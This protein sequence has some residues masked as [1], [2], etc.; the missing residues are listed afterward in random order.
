MSLYDLRCLSCGYLLEV[1]HRL[2]ESP[3]IICPQC[4]IPMA[5]YFGRQQ[6]PMTNLGFRE[7]H[8]D[9]ETDRGIAKFQFT[10]DKH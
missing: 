5:R 3:F 4:Q 10:N 7:D 9:N 2:G 1:Q 6:M 8:Y